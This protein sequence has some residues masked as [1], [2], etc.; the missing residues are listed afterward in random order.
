MFGNGVKIFLFKEKDSQL[1]E[2]PLCFG[3]I[4]KDF[5][6]DNIRKTALCGYMYDFSVDYNSIDIDDVLGIH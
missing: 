3:N 2:K 5:T 4:L 1:R 6:V